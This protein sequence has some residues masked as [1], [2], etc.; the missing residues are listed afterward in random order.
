LIPLAFIYVANPLGRILNEI[1]LSEIVE[2]GEKLLQ[3]DVQVL[4]RLVHEVRVT[5]GPILW[6]RFGRNLRTKPT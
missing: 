4:A 1:P 3:R 5:L 2:N 6:I